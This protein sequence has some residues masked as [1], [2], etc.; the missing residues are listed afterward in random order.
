[1]NRRAALACRGS[2]LTRRPIGFFGEFRRVSPNAGLDGEPQDPRVPGRHA[3]QP[4]C[5][6][7]HLGEASG[8]LQR[9][10]ERDPCVDR[11]RDLPGGLTVQSYGAVEIAGPRQDAPG[12]EQLAVIVRRDAACR[13]RIA[14]GS[15]RNARLDC[16]HPGRAV[17]ERRSQPPRHLG[18]PRVGAQGQERANAFQRHRLE[19]SVAAAD[20]NPHQFAVRVHH[21]AAADAGLHARANV[22]P[23]QHRAFRRP[24]RSAPRGQT[25]APLSGLCRRRRRRTRP[26]P[27]RPLRGPE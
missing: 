13:Q 2:A 5:V 24:P 22:E 4:A 12:F 18:G 17:R 7:C 26:C 11:V 6:P 14:V 1:M 19:P 15:A 20:G 25:R 3:H 8:E 9:H 27:G 21:G 10:Q 16:V 23:S